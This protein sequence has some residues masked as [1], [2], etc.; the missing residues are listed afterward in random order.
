MAMTRNDIWAENARH[1]FNA[2]AGPDQRI[3]KHWEWSLSQHWEAG[4]KI[5]LYVLRNLPDV[6]EQAHRDAPVA[7]DYGCESVLDRKDNNWNV[8]TAFGQPKEGDPEYDQY[9][10]FIKMSQVYKPPRYHFGHECHGSPWHHARQAL[11]SLMRQHCE[12]G[13]HFQ[14]HPDWSERWEEYH[15]GI[16]KICEEA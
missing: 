5:Y 16:L 15:S 6:P 7:Y 12:L 10:K 13:L 8:F 1:E 11:R 14:R 9:E 4:R 2:S 3:L